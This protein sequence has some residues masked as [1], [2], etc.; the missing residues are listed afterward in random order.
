MPTSRGRNTLLAEPGPDKAPAKDESPA[1]I[2]H[3]LLV[4]T[5]NRGPESGQSCGTHSGSSRALVLIDREV[6]RQGGNVTEGGLEGRTLRR[7]GQGGTINP[8]GP[9][10]NGRRCFTQDKSGRK[11][12]QEVVPP[13]TGSVD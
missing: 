12:D 1:L 6:P 5:G 9:P 11:G 13:V 10:T 7:V 3:K 4:G 2:I 8:G